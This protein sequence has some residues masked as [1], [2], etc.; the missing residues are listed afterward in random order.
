MGPPGVRHSRAERARAEPAAGR[1]VIA[2]SDL[3][4]CLFNEA[5]RHAHSELSV[6]LWRLRLPVETYAAIAALLLDDQRREQ[7]LSDVGSLS[8]TPAGWLWPHSVRT[9][10]VLERRRAPDTSLRDIGGADET[11]LFQRALDW[12][13]LLRLS[14]LNA[15]RHAAV[16][17]PSRTWISPPSRS[18]SC[19][20]AGCRRQGLC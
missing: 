19:R 2:D 4:A 13:I 14:R 7:R 10:R 15:I 8:R 17:P 12:D 6:F 20:L 18:A 11:P 3:P 5:L 16:T 9:P 1:R